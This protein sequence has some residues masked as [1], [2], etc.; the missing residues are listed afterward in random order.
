VIVQPKT[1]HPQL[2]RKNIIAKTPEDAKAIYLAR[3]GSLADGVELIVEAS[4]GDE[5]GSGNSGVVEGDAST[6][7]TDSEP[8][9]VDGNQAVR[10]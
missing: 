9:G 3:F 8:D 10:G 4:N 7:G 5:F 6:G 1:E 2:G